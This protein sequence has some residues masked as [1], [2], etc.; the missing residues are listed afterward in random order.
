MEPAI[1]E[2]NRAIFLRPRDTKMFAARGDAFARI[3]DLLATACY[4]IIGRDDVKKV[5]VGIRQ[6]LTCG[7]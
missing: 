7:M 6:S 3:H 2:L 1:L 4:T 5:L